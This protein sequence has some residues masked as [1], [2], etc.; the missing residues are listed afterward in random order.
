LTAN[1]AHTYREAGREGG[2]EGC[3]CLH[4]KTRRFRRGSDNM[5][6][7]EGRERGREGGREDKYTHR[8][9]HTQ[10]VKA[11]GEAGREGGREGGRDVPVASPRTHSPK[12][13]GTGKGS[14]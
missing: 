6:M 9:R 12:A 13:A 5:N 4:F 3:E 1:S 11:G 10:G 8:E 14:E 2:R 7:E